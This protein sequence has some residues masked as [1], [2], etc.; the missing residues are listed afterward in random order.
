[1]GKRKADNHDASEVLLTRDVRRAILE[2]VHPEDL[3]ALAC[4]C[5]SWYEA[6]RE[7]GALAKRGVQPWA[8][9]FVFFA[10]HLRHLNRR[11]ESIMIRA[12]PLRFKISREALLL[13][14]LNADHKP[15]H[16]HEFEHLSRVSIPITYH[17]LR[18]HPNGSDAGLRSMD[19]TR[20]AALM[21]AVVEKNNM[22]VAIMFAT[23]VGPR[24]IPPL[25]SMLCAMM[26]RSFH[27]KKH[28]RALLDNH[29]TPGLQAVLV[30]YV[31]PNVDD[32]SRG[33]I[34]AVLIE[35]NRFAG[36]I[37]EHDLMPPFD[38]VPLNSFDGLRDDQKYAVL[39]NTR[40][41]TDSGIV[42][43]VV[44]GRATAA[45]M[46]QHGLYVFRHTPFSVHGV[47]AGLGA[48]AIADADVCTRVLALSARCKSGC[49]VTD[50]MA[51]AFDA[52][53]NPRFVAHYLESKTPHE[54]LCW[55]ARKGVLMPALKSTVFP[56]LPPDFLCA[57]RAC[58]SL[59]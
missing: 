4:T 26:C 27:S 5:K 32:G 56:L 34:L 15:A 51:G 25:D 17:I 53:T 41:C 57:V 54:A 29:M 35:T 9:R 46:R 2:R 21:A 49:I 52:T 8:S 42:Q 19:N 38:A 55:I 43:S 45:L 47:R 59:I 50:R 7:V 44:R 23:H 28:W 14:G 33:A 3:F 1:M 48:G 16:L 6:V 18:M 22:F 10:A 13:R 58:D 36:A 11:R 30:A 39:Q 37:F 40:G 20:A 12:H 24:D 31:Y